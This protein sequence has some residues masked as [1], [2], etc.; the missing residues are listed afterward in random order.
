MSKVARYLLVLLGVALAGHAALLL[1]GA[2][3]FNRRLDDEISAACDGELSRDDRSALSR[4]N[5]IGDSSF[6][7]CWENAL[8]AM[9]WHVSSAPA[10]FALFGP[11]TVDR[12]A[13]K[14]RIGIVST[15]AGKVLAI[16]GALSG[17]VRAGNNASSHSDGEAP[18]NELPEKEILNPFKGLW[19]RGA[20]CSWAGASDLPDN[21]AVPAP[22]AAG[23]SFTLRGALPGTVA[24]TATTRFPEGY[25]SGNSAATIT[26][27]N[28]VFGPFNVLTMELGGTAQGVE[29]DHLIFTGTATLG[30]TLDVVLIN[31]FDPAPGETF[32]LFDGA[33]TGAFA[34]INLPALDPGF[35]WDTSQFATAGVL[36]V[37]PEPGNA[38]LALVGFLFLAAGRWRCESGRAEPRSPRSGQTLQS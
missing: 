1:S 11:T 26:L 31:N 17:V 23:E 7:F 34:A 28:P 2:Q 25:L 4:V 6:I 15:Q 10:L 33:T 22:I 27:D 20:I 9:S 19:Q 32:D 38:A 37:V 5:G 16:S 8:P 24:F 35:S 30:G 14:P 3:P 29:Y 21:N 36:V 12:G 18:A 13:A